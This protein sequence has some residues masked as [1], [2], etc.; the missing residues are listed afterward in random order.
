[1]YSGQKFQFQAYPKHM[2]IIVWHT[3]H[4][5]GHILLPQP[6]RKQPKTNPK[7]LQV[8]K[9]LYSVK[10]TSTT[11]GA[12]TNKCWK[13]PVQP[14]INSTKVNHHCW[15]LYNK[16]YNTTTATTTVRPSGPLQKKILKTPIQPQNNS[17]NVNHHC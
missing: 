7:Q 12:F 2:I 3:P 16:K 17:S 10:T 9:V 1:M 6:N 14:Q 13:T 11:A 15:G 4:T 8:G 5:R